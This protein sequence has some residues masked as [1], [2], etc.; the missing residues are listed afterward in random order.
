[1]F[2]LLS[3]GG[4]LHQYSVMDTKDNVVEVVSE[5]ELIHI[6]KDLDIKIVGISCTNNTI[7]TKVPFVPDASGVKHLVWRD[8][9]VVCYYISVDG[10]KYDLYLSI[11]N[12]KKN[13]YD[14]KIT[15]S[16]IKH[17][18]WF[19]IHASSQDS[20]ECVVTLGYYDKHYYREDQ[21]EDFSLE[22]KLTFDN[23]KL[24]IKKDSYFLPSDVE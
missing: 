18:P 21:G 15:Y 3:S 6:L 2:Y 7:E 10:Y 12:V 9:I 16:G 11:Y 8:Y 17:Y 1:M 23:G 19:A 5:D 13:E 20:N 22:V 14:G 24:K 4:N